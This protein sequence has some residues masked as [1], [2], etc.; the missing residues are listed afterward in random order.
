[1]MAVMGKYAEVLRH[2]NFRLLFL[3]SAISAARNTFTT[4]ALAFGVLAVTGSV[5][6]IGVVVAARQVAQVVFLLVG[7]A[8]GTASCG[9]G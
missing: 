6:A 8:W 1:M 2:R 4:V 3:A 5:T 7:G 9:L